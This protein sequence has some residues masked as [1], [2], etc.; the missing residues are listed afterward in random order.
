MKKF[1]KKVISFPFAVIGI[2]CFLIALAIVTCS[3]EKMANAMHAIL[4]T[5]EENEQGI[6]EKYQ[7]GAPE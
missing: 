2:I 5:L 4:T 3:F 7:A 6:K 1:I